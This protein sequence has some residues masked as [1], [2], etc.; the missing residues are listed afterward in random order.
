MLAGMKV[1]ARCLRAV[2]SSKIGR[3]GSPFGEV[4]HGR[5]VSVGSLW[6]VLYSFVDPIQRED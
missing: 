6:L 1:I 4:P 5:D 2:R 3:T